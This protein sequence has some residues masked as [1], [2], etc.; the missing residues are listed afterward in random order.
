MGHG[1]V[2]QKNTHGGA[3]GSGN[4]HILVPLG[5][6]AFVGDGEPVHRLG[7]GNSE[8]FLE[9]IAAVMIGPR[10][11]GR[12]VQSVSLGSPHIIAGQLQAFDMQSTQLGSRTDLLG[13]NPDPI[14]QQRTDALPSGNQ[15]Q[16]LNHG[17]MVAEFEF[18][19]AGIGR[20]DDPLFI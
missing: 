1:H 8:N 15:S 6:L 11:R 12:I 7:N 2:Q 13:C 4:A 19:S 20:L 10:K 16:Q 9:S 18:D 5:E 17:L 3:V 14:G